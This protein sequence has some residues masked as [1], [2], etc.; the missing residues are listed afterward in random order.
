MAQPAVV[1]GDSPPL[2]RL[3]APDAATWTR[4]RA[5]KSVDPR[6]SQRGLTLAHVGCVRRSALILM[7]AV[8]GCVG[9]A[10]TGGGAVE[11]RIIGGAADGADPAV[12]VIYLNQPGHADGQLCTGEVISPHVVLTA[13]HCAGGADPSVTNMLFR[14][15]LGSDFGAATTATMLPASAAHYH[16]DFDASNLGA[17]SDVGVIVLRDALPATLVPL[18]FNR[19]S[20]DAGFDGRTVRFVGYGLDNATTQTGGGIKRATTTT[21]TNHTSL[22]LHFS[23]GTHETCNGDSGGPA[24]MTLD[25]RDTIVGLTSYGDVGVRGRRLRHARRCVRR[26]D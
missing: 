24:L 1:G 16:P 25:G 3:Q 21:L 14:V 11:E 5:G 15:Y 2:R 4:V 18:P 8:G 13:A 23:D 20:M 12:V 6:P 10:T 7:L 26:L 17:G 19:A 9:A 22:L